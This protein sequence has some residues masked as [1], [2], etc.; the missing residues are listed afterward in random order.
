MLC[1][2]ANCINMYPS[3]TVKACSLWDLAN[4]HLAC[5]LV[6]LPMSNTV[7]PQARRQRRSEERPGRQS[8]AI[9]RQK[10]DNTCRAPRALGR[11]GER[12]RVFSIADLVWISTIL[13]LK[14]CDFQKNKHFFFAQMLWIYIHFYVGRGQQVKDFAPVWVWSF[15]APF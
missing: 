1:V 10:R 13:N 9:S 5:V 8:A 11:E 14:Q 4:Q 7:Q 12:S 15:Q 6:C 3:F 2:F